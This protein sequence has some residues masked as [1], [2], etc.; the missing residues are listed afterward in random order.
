MGRTLNDSS[1]PKSHHPSKGISDSGLSTAQ[2]GNNTFMK[3]E[4]RFN[5][6]FAGYADITQN[7]V[8]GAY[9]LEIDGDLQMFDGET[10]ADIIKATLK[11]KEFG[12]FSSERISV[13][14][15]TDS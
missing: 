1:R 2:A 11:A 13:T 15:F 12:Q 8:N 10:R 6:Q 3:F 7:N 5:G 4:V 9:L 14:L